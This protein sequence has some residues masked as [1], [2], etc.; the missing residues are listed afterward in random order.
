MK[1]LLP[2]ILALGT[3]LIAKAQET[4]SSYIIYDVKQ[5]KEVNLKELSATVPAGTVL[6]FGEQHDD[7]IA[8]SLQYQLL[9]LLQQEWGSK[10]VLLSM[11]MFQKDVQYIVDEYLKGLISEKNFIK[12][13]R[14]WN[15]Y[16]DYKPMVEYAKN[17][18]IGIL[19][20]NTPSRYTNMVTTKG[21]GSLELLSKE[22]KKLYLPPLPVDTLTGGYY[23]RFLE[24]MGGHT[25]P[26]FNL[27]QS[28]NVWDATMAH[29]IAGKSGKYRNGIIYHLCGRFHSDYGEG[30]AFRLRKAYDLPVMI[31]SSF[32]QEDISQTNW[33]D[34]NKIG[35][36]V[37]VT[38]SAKTVSSA[39]SKN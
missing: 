9:Q 28:Q 23:D 37:I 36:Y 20:A 27:Y 21:L 3:T 32:Y 29:S 17:H 39:D 4:A 19:A 14:A 35:D 15:N 2:L 31:I 8:H 24:A 6:I 26:G 18:G 25:I 22:T 5:Q 38:K 7:S 10:K 13:A 33:A 12:E 11:E 34:W 16:N 30:T 1:K